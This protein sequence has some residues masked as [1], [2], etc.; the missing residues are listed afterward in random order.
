MEEQEKLVN[1]I[2]MLAKKA[3]E[4]KLTAEE[5]IQQEKLRKQYLANFREGFK[6]QIEM[7]QVFDKKGAEVTPEK[8]KKIQREKGLRD[9]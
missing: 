4:G 8:V 6:S 9:D 7:M 2:N 1:E 3:K 5:K